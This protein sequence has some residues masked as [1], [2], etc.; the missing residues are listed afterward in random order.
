QRGLDATFPVLG[1]LLLLGQRSLEAVA[2][3]NQ[4]FG[5][6]LRAEF[7]RLGNVF[8]GAAADVLDL[9]VGAQQLIVVIG[10]L[11]LRS[12]QQRGQVLA[13]LLGRVRLRRIGGWVLGARRGLR[14]QV[15]LGSRHLG[16]S[17][18]EI[19]E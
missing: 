10:D 7:A 2:H 8:L 16:I 15:F 6:G 17:N 5:K 11:L 14:I 18:A 3:G 12:I 9:G 13:R 1:G 19:N 4:A